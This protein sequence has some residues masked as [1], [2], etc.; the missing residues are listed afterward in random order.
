MSEDT[1]QFEYQS[2]TREFYQSEDTAEEYHESFTQPGGLDGVRFRVVSSRERAAVAG[3]LDRVSHESIVDIPVGTGKLAPVLAE[4]GGDILSVDISPQMIA[5]ARSEYQQL[6]YSDV[7]FICGD[8]EQLSDTV[9]RQFDVVVCL[10]LL[11]RVPREKKRS[12]LAEL[13]A[14]T[15]YAIVSFGVDSRYHSARRRLRQRL[16]GGGDQDYDPCYE[17]RAVIETLVADHFDIVDSTWVVPML[18]Q[19]IV[20]LLRSTTNESTRPD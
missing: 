10:R 15:D 19:E 8:A 1:D 2:D 6:G 12:I 16:L 13:A 18:S 11:H 5:I 14:V 4:T 20:Y 7:E 3:F 17:S 9:D